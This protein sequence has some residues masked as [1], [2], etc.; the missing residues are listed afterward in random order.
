[1]MDLKN[2]SG[3]SKVKSLIIFIVDFAKSL[4]LTPITRYTSHP[5][6]LDLLFHSFPRLVVLCLII[7]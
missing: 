2:Y 6:K 7:S 4:L 1:M 5:L 3:C